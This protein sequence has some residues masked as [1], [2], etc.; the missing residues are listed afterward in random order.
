MD[1]KT[2]ASQVTV[3]VL[4]NLLVKLIWIFFIERKVQITVG[5]QN[6]GL[7]YSIFSF[8]LIL[9]V[10]NDP[11]L[12]NYLVQ[13]LNKGE[14]H[15]NHISNL[16]Y[17]KTFL[18]G[19]YVFISVSIGLLLGFNNYNLLGLLIL[20]QVLF[21]LLTYLRSFLKGHQLLKSEIFFSVLDKG[22]FIIAFLP[23]LFFDNSFSWTVS[24]YVI[25]QI[26]AL[27]LA[28]IL[29]T[30]HLYRK[31]IFVFGV[32]KSIP[33]LA[34]QEVN[35]F[36]PQQGGFILGNEKKA[37]LKK[38]APFAVFAFLVLAYNKIDTV[39]LAKMLPDGD[40]QNGV[41]VAAYRFLDAAS[42]FP[43]LF[44]TLF[45]PVLC[46]IISDKK[47]TAELINNSIAV[48]MPITII[49]AMASWF[50]R[51]HLMALLYAQNG[52]A[53][54]ALIFG[55]LMFSL[56]LVV[57]Y[58]VFST[59]FTASNRLRLLNLISAAGLAVNIGLNTLLI[60]K[61]QALGAA[62]SSLASFFI[63]GLTYLI[64]YHVVFKHPFPKVIWIKIF[65]LIVLLTALG[66]LT[67]CIPQN[68]MSGFSL[69][70]LLATLITG[71]L[72]FFDIRSIRYSL[73]SKP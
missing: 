59:F 2:F 70:L 54:L 50:Y 52:G 32:Q 57:I 49:I 24:F 72:Q 33:D 7:Y 69:Y 35:H 40:M 37:I 16:F 21:S 9:G 30:L 36:P 1:K 42:M 10:I 20:Y 17:I 28:L 6:F 27:T 3:L 23:V 67:I 53:T 56:P 34:T 38:I 15:T 14:T 68:W 64:F 44:A 5:F 19:L 8:T 47:K 26:I 39:M 4:V 61:Y 51:D 13:Y 63:I 12:N 25:A 29:C 18:A 11:G 22:L 73:G 66:Y 46:K 31:K 41:Y 60:P 58:Y 48:L 55:I 71:L 62:L 65:A 43:I 45:F